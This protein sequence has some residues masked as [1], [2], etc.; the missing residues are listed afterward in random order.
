ME[1]I[2]IT[3]LI[4]ALAVVIIGFVLYIR[5]LDKD[6]VKQD[7]VILRLSDQYTTANAML[8]EYQRKQSLTPMPVKPETKV[9]QKMS[10]AQIRHLNSVVNHRE[11]EESEKKADNTA[12]EEE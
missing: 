2:I 5:I 11:R 1:T 8:D 12:Y 7:A 6:I 3:A 10:Y 9:A 4:G